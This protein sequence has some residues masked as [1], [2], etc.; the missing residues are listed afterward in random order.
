MQ[1]LPKFPSDQMSARMATAHPLLPY[2]KAISL[3]PPSSTLLTADGGRL[4]VTHERYFFVWSTRYY[5]IFRELI[6]YYTIFCKRNFFEKI[7]FF[8]KAR[9]GNSHLLSLDTLNVS[10]DN[11]RTFLP[12]VASCQNAHLEKNAIFFTKIALAKYRVISCNIV[13]TP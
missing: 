12:I 3:E 6:R 7:A 5:T 2:L 1:G 8:L 11:I 10:N 13:S 4:E 9:S